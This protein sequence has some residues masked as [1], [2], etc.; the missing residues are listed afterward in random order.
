[1]DAANL[2]VWLPFDE[3]TTLDKCGNTWTTSG[4]PTISATN[5][6]SGN[7]LQLNGSSYLRTENIELGGQDF[8][9]DG[10]LY[11]NSTTPAQACIVLLEKE[12]GCPLLT[13]GKG[14]NYPER[15]RIGVTPTSDVSTS[16]ADS[17]YRSAITNVEVANKRV[18]FELDYQFNE[19]VLKFYINGVRSITLTNV[20]RFERRNFTLTIG[21]F[22]R[23]WGS[24]ESRDYYFKGYLD[25]FRIF[26]GLVLHTDDFTPPTVAE[27]TA[28]TLPPKE[29]TFFFD[30][31][32]KVN[33]IITFAFDAD[34]VIRDVLPVSSTADV[35]RR[36]TAQV[37]FSADI[38]ICDVF[39]FE[40]DADINRAIKGKVKL[41]AVDNTA[42][43]PSGGTSSSGDSGTVLP[44][45]IPPQE[46]IPAAINNTIGLQSIEISLS[47]QQLTDNVA[48][49][50]VVPFD[51]MFPV[52]GQ[53]LDYVF[54]MRVER[55]QQKGVLYSCDCCIDIDQLLYTQIAYT[56]A[57]STDWHT[58]G[59]SSTATTTS[60]VESVSAMYHALQLA[61]VLG[62]TPVIQFDDFQSTVL[63]EN[64]GGVTYADMIRDIFGWSARVPTQMINVFVRNDKI[65]FVQ[66]GHEARL[67]DLTLAKYTVPTVTHEIVRMTW[68]STPWSKTETK[69]T[70]SYRPPNTSTT[71]GNG[72]GIADIEENGGTAQVVHDEWFGQPE[73]GYVNYTYNR[74]G[75]LIQS[76]TYVY[77][78]ETT[79]STYTTV[80][81]AYDT[82]GTLIYTGTFVQ[83]MGVTH[84]SNYSSSNTEEN[85]SYIKLPNGEKF[86]ARESIVR[87]VGENSLT[88]TELAES[89]T[90]IHSPTRAGQSHTTIINDGETV[91]GIVGQN[92]GDD[93]VTP[94]SHYKA[95]SLSD[96]FKNSSGGAKTFDSIDNI[97]SSGAYYFNR[98]T[99]KWEKI[100]ETVDTQ[101]RTLNGLSLYDSSFPIHNVEKLVELTAAVQWLNRRTKETV[102]FTL[103][104]YP[105]LID[106]NDRI[107]FNGAE[108]FL[109]SNIATTNARVFNEQRIS[110]VRWY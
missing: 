92:T 77:N 89:K 30:V 102:N 104:E 51:V 96:S 8:S 65:F 48:F 53:Y 93:R 60:E 33:N 63:M 57:P 46:T 21:Y 50:G 98:E 82:D 109:V 66:R 73:S 43:F 85:K 44:V 97:E 11:M 100:N 38:V 26:D 49:T 37:E 76:F 47:E 61:A 40:F 84:G 67:I 75:L 81:H 101:S 7:A 13:I 107:I 23:T 79:Q 10:W 55:V 17:S 45:V 16:P 54:D 2:K 32:R 39:P 34:I 25:E 22:Y 106:F 3:S 6:I 103:Y 86:L 105:H 94:F 87:Y 68:G 52:Q 5:A 24:D 91:G 31:Q 41:F 18:H 59:D 58:S 56:V 78:H 80:N 62:K 110:L 28:V 19:Q 108:Y 14:S 12:L 69:E 20:A 64:A 1:M 72:A 29:K 88:P 15:L 70:K 74:K 9:I 4:T 36:L 35:E 27:Y 95:G 99:G 90:I 42:Y 83:S 71:S